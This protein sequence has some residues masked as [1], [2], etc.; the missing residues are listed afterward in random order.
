MAL[1]AARVLRAGGSGVFSGSGSGSALG[2]GGGGQS[3]TT[4]ARGA[5]GAGSG[6]DSTRAEGG[7]LS[8]SEA[9][10]GAG[11]GGSAGAGAGAGAARVC[12]EMKWTGVQPMATSREIGASSDWKREYQRMGTTAA[13]ARRD[14]P[15]MESI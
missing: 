13:D 8:G 15:R 10:S 12:R 5:G 2:S 1:A 6:G 4:R 9:S 7:G 3:A 14:L 11:A